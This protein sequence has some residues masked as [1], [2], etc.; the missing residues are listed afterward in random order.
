MNI[1]GLTMREISE[2]MKPYVADYFKG[3][4]ITNYEGELFTENYTLEFGEI[5]VD[6]PDKERFSDTD[7]INNASG[8]IY[9]ANASDGHKGFEFVVILLSST[10][11][12]RAL[13]LILQKISESTG[14]TEHIILKTGGM[15]WSY[16]DSAITPTTSAAT[17]VSTT[18][19]SRRQTS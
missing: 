11:Y 6:L 15:R 3:S 1:K 5:G 2:K 9:I 18:S 10:D 8:Y 13:Y 19:T 12:S 17:L 7:Q 4:T 14:K 16:A